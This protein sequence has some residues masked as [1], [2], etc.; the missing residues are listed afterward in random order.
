MNDKSI[1]PDPADKDH[2]SVGVFDDLSDLM[3]SGSKVITGSG[4]VFYH[5][6][7]WFESVGGTWHVF[8]MNDMPK[9]IVDFIVKSRLGGDNLKPL[10]HL[11]NE[12]PQFNSPVKTIAVLKPEIELQCPKCKKIYK[13]SKMPTLDCYALDLFQITPGCC[14]IHDLIQINE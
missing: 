5:L 13:A 2:I 3:E 7:Y 6:P 1:L 12:Y 11:V 14:D 10:N 9:E 8:H 4:R